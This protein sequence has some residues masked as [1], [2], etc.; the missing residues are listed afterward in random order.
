MKCK[1]ESAGQVLQIAV[2]SSG[3]K[4]ERLL[5]LIPDAKQKEGKIYLS[6]EVGFNERGKLGIMPR[7]I[8]SCMYYLSQGIAV[9]D[10]HYECGLVKWHD[11]EE[12]EQLNA[13]LS[14][15]FRVCSSSLPPKTCYV[16][17]QYRKNWYYIEDCDRSSKTTFA[18]LLLLYNLHATEESRSIGPILTLPLK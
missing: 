11:G 3:P 1:E 15:L 9:P 14:G 4:A 13:A 6:M 10:I 7:T 16:A 5:E 17:V 12:P 18:L 2:P 8:L